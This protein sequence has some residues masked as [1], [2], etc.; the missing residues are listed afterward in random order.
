MPTLN[1]TILN[2]F[3]MQCDQQIVFN[4]VSRHFIMLSVKEPL[5]VLTPQNI[6]DSTHPQQLT[7]HS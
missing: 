4:H 7:N 6:T 1:N 2:Q 5:P 3:S